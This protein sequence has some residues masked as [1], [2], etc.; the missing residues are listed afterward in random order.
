MLRRGNK[1]ITGCRGREG[2][3]WSRSRYGKRQE[4]RTDGQEN[5]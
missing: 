2:K 1:I 5:E 3:G 4:R